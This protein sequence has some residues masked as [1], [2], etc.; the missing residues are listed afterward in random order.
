MAGI[1]GLLLSW[2]GCL[3]EGKSESPIEVTSD[4]SADG[5]PLFLPKN[6]NPSKINP[7]KVACFSSPKNDRLLSSFHQQSTTHLPS[8]NHVLHPVFAKTP[9]K[10]PVIPARK[11]TAK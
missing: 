8:K 6:G 11:N 7:E 10:T 1:C 2:C 4:Q 9:A 3:R 5:L